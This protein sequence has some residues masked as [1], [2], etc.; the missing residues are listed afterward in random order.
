MLKVWYRY[1]QKRPEVG[2]NYFGSWSRDPRQAL[3]DAQASFVADP[4]RPVSIE[5]TDSSGQ[6]VNCGWNAE[7]VALLATYPLSEQDTRQWYSHFI[8][9]L[10][11]NSLVSPQVK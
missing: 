4:Q 7:W 5:R 2:F 9:L 10:H 6:W 1:A 3:K 11:A 8:Q